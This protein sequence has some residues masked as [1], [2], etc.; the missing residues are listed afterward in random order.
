MQLC[1]I[2]CTIFF[3]EVLK[4]AI[5]NSFLM[6]MYVVD[7]LVTRL[8]TKHCPMDGRQW[9]KNIKRNYHCILESVIWSVVLLVH[10]VPSG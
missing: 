1:L 3:T 5:L 10:A 2:C 9:G 7:P 4:V 6:G 8:Q